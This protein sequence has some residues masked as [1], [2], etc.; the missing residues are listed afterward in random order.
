[1][2]DRS[3]SRVLLIGWDAADWQMI[4]PLIERGLMPNLERMINTGVMGNIATLTPIIS[5]ILWNSIATGKTGDKHGI[6]GFIEPDGK[7]NVRPVSS[8]SRKAKAIW[9]IASQ[10]GL[11]SNVVNWY[12]S[13]PAER[14]HGCVLT[15]RY[16]RIGELR[17]DY[18]ACDEKAIHPERLREEL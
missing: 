7:G 10:N 5:P 1:M 4:N 13:H 3:G 12:A 2:A 6:L 9:N 8:T 14:V 17:A 16:C 15:D 11:R 18:P